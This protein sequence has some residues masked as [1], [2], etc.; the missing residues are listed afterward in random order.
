MATGFGAVLCS[1]GFVLIIF[2]PLFIFLIWDLNSKVTYQVTYKRIGF[3]VD[4]FT[5]FMK[6]KGLADIQK[7]LENKHDPWNITILAIKEIG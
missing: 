2:S 5:V 6:A 7:Q 4:T 3:C 1:I